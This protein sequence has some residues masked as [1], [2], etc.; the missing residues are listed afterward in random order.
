M[1][2]DERYNVFAYMGDG[3]KTRVLISSHLDTVPPFWPYERRGENGEEVWGRG[4]VDAKG[5]VATQ[6]MAVEQL[7]ED[8]EIEE[9]DVAML[10]VLG[11]G[12]F[13]PKDISS[14]PLA[15]RSN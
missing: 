4:S 14:F 3:R 11:E 2:D 5:S 15:F 6:I 12:K 7:L 1:T 9:G 13:L 10:F 8:G